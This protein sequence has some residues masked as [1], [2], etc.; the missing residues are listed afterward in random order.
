V[1]ALLFGGIFFYVK[2]YS[3]RR[4]EERAKLSFDRAIQHYRGLRREGLLNTSQGR[5][6]LDLA[7][8]E[9]VI[10]TDPRFTLDEINLIRIAGDTNPGKVH[11][12]EGNFLVSPPLREETEHAY[13]IYSLA[14]SERASRELLEG[15]LASGIALFL[16]ATAF[17]QLLAHEVTRPLRT[18]RQ[19]IRSMASTLDLDPP[20]EKGDELRALTKYYLDFAQHLQTAFEH[21]KLAIAE[22]ET[23]KAELL[24]VNGNLHRRLFQVKV[25]LSLWSERDKALDVKDFLSRFLEMLLPGLPFEYGCVIIRPIADMGSET[26]FAKK[27]DATT[28]ARPGVRDLEEDQ[29]GSSITLWTDIVDPQVRAYLMRESESCMGVNAVTIGKV[30]GRIRT[31]SP[32][33]NITVLSLR[34]QQGDE[35]LG[36]VHFLTEQASPM[37]SGALSEF[38]L[39]LSAQVAA[40]LQIQALSYATRVDPLTR[41]YNRGYLNDR[42]REELVRSARKHEPFSLILLDIDGY[43]GIYE[44]HGQQMADKVIRDVASLLKR[45][46]RGS[47]AICRFSGAVMAIVLADT[48]LSGAKIFAEN[49]RKTVEAEKF[50]LPEGHLQ[51]TVSMGLAEFPAHADGVEELLASADEAL[52]DTK[53]RGANSW[54]VAA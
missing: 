50:E 39:N 33:A 54:K 27:L 44:K 17:S 12:S 43:S 3:G 20:E 38:L 31:D 2:G 15:L 41:L 46:C 22:L 11:L 45:S 30:H 47:D 21:K 6:L 18:L 36:S 8:I 24:R 5:H 14:E 25:L 35:P 9:R 42:L 48:P 4:E 34:L 29:S 19:K 37:I 26:I 10:L 13:L 7:G 32:P 53:D 28:G 1:L 49:V 52:R 40:Q 16:L 23:Y 51:V